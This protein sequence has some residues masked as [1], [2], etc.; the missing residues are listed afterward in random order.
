MPAV[1]QAWESPFDA[2]APIWEAE[3]R[4]P[5]PS[6]WASPLAAWTGAPSRRP[7]D[8][9][10]ENP[11]AEP[12]SQAPAD[13]E[14]GPVETEGG[15]VSPQITEAL[16][17]RDWPAALRLA[18]GQG[19]R[20]D[21][22]LA[23]LVF[24]ARH[25]ELGGRALDPRKAAD[26]ALAQ[27]WVTIRD[28][29]VWPV[30]EAS[31]R[32]ASLAASGSLAAAGHRLFWGPAGR[33]FTDLVVAAARDVD[34]DP[35]LLAST[36]LAEAG[37]E[38]FLT[39]DRVSSYEVG[40]DDFYERRAALA[41]A[42][43]AYRKVG[44]DRQQTP[45]EHLN[46]AQRNRR[47]VKTIDFDSGPDAL[48]ACAVYL[49]YGE[50]VLR[51]FAA[52]R[53][54][55]F[56]A[57]PVEVRFALT[58]MAFAAGPGGARSRLDSALDGKDVLVR[59]DAPLRIYQTDRNATVRSAQ[60]LHLD[61]WIFKTG[62][63]A[64][65][66]AAPAPT[67][68]AGPAWETARAG[69]AEP[70]GELLTEVTDAVQ[71]VLAPSM[72]FE[73][74]DSL[75]GRMLR[76][77]AANIAVGNALDRGERNENALT[78]AGFNARHPTRPVGPIRQD[79]PRFA[80]LRAD[81]LDVRSRIVRP[82]LAERAAKDRLAHLVPRGRPPSRLCCLV[83]ADVLEPGSPGSHGDPSEALG[84]VFTD[85]LG[86]IDLGHARE[87]A[88]VTLWALNQLQAVGGAA[89]HDI[90]LFHGTA[91]LLRD[92]P[93]ER[94][95]ALAQQLA[96]VDSVAHEIE[97]FGVWGP[98]MDN[99]SF[100]P[101][102]LPSNLFGTV[103]AAGAFAADGGSNTAITD[104]LKRLLAAAGAQPAQVG[105]AAQAVA[106]HRGWW[107]ATSGSPTL[108][109]LRKRNLQAVPWLIDPH[110][111]T[112]IQPSRLLAEPPLASPDFAYESRATHI[113]SGDFQATIDG[114]RASLPA[115]ALVP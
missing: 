37:R 14:R 43:P 110:G 55:D 45:R 33:R 102:D 2:S 113:K 82:A 78:D 31:A 74:G 48:L 72:S 63:P 73:G 87:T 62:V 23:N 44:W 35:G 18:I 25:P 26:A 51:K 112:R 64:A 21:G 12:G 3:D 80:E 68:E 97:T 84:E 98:G 69:E 42:V 47:L 91:R 104:E 90:D 1:H 6:R 66:P 27:E 111:G 67:P 50:V 107:E 39:A 106:L 46:D 15:V 65:A 103:V 85:K 13:V 41:A 88:D 52:D 58:R 101:E 59:N 8:A 57:L 5:E 108:F 11:P 20:D 56:D 28:R 70:A 36:L 24:F 49:K 34:L 53:H 114:L 40:T 109:P 75:I 96:Y 38:S 16:D 7:R 105:R 60:A 9:D 30:I 94:R 100:S 79:D 89:T 29:E 93:V 86:F 17:R 81:W 10:D 115:S 19:W 83:W 32:N 54:G 95:L 61:E 77:V 22:E 71:R 99:S 4:P 92:I 76:D